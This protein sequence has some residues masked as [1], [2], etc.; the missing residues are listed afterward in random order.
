MTANP[1]L[2][3]D[4]V[5]LYAAFVALDSCCNEGFTPNPALLWTVTCCSTASVLIWV[6]ATIKTFMRGLYYDKRIKL[7]I[8]DT[9]IRIAFLGVRFYPRT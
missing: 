9:T 7:V 8:T 3:N 4:F 5:A 2:N 1:S 6:S